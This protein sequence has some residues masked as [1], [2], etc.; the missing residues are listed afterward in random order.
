[1]RNANELNEMMLY[2]IM[3]TKEAVEEMIN[4]GINKDLNVERLNHMIKKNKSLEELIQRYARVRNSWGKTDSIVKVIG[5]VITLL[6]GISIILL[7][8]IGGIVAIPLAMIESILGETATL[9]GFTSVMISMG[10]T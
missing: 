3:K 1:M 8:V 4:T 2:P 7:P 5:S 9:T 10:W 6:M